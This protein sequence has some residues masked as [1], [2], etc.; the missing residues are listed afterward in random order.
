[1]SDEVYQKIRQAMN[2]GWPL[3]LPK[4]KSVME[5][6][7]IIYPTEEEAKIVACFEQPMFDLKSVRKLCKMHNITIIP[8]YLFL[9]KKRLH[10]AYM[11]RVFEK[12]AIFRCLFFPLFGCTLLFF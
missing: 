2:N 8:I 9:D 7:K 6:L 3:K 12:I 4:E 5:V 10:T 1:M 11:D